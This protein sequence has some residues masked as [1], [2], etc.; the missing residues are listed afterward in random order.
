MPVRTM[1]ENAIVALLPHGK[2]QFEVVAKML[3]MSER[4][5][6]RRLAREGYA[7][8]D[9]L[10]ELRRDLAVHYLEDKG[11]QMSQIA[12]RLGFTYASALSHAC[13][14]WFNKSPVEYRR[15]TAA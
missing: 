8:G 14:R 7:F 9:I 13:R 15:A 2:A 11:M 10:E 1:V 4:T 6:A 3:N 5:L 12:W